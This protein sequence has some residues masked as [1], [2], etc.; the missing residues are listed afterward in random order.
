MLKS[1]VKIK[2]SLSLK[3]LSTNI[4]FAF[5]IVIV[6]DVIVQISSYQKV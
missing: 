1:W 3:V 2:Q 5:I 6:I 4:L